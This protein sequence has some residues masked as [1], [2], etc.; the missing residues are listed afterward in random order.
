MYVCD[1]IEQKNIYANASIEHV[2]G[3]RVEEILAIGPWMLSSLIHAEDAIKMPD[4]LQQVE[5][6]SEGDIFEIEYR[7]R[8]KDGSWRWIVSR[9]TVFAKTAEGKLKLILG[10]G[11]DITENKQAEDEIKLLL[12]ATQAISRSADFHSALPD[13]VNAKDRMDRRCF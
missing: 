2:L 3:Y 4:Y 7:V 9:D 12:A 5:A 13:L 6:G 10:T 1:L 8:H 11:T